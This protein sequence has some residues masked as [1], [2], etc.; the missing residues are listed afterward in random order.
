MLRYNSACRSGSVRLTATQEREMLSRRSAIRRRLTTVR[1]VQAIYMSGVPALVAAHRQSTPADNHP[2]DEPLFTPSQLSVEGLASCSPG[3]ADIEAR[4]RDA[5]LHE[6]LDEMRTL[7]H[8]KAG[9]V[10][11]KQRHVRHQRP[12]TR[13]RSIIEN[14][15]Q[16]IK[17]YSAKY[18]AARVAKLALTGPGDWEMTW[19]KLEDQD[20]RTM[21]ADD[22]PANAKNTETGEQNILLSEG[23]RLTSWI[24]MGA[25]RDTTNAAGMQDGESKSL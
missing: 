21:L 1:A 7:L 16:R 15:E 6:C 14:N 11:H 12:N 22:D 18:R 10:I 25:D 20:I 4:L 5:Q 2:E 3:I 8:L 17:T 9:L 24:W 19:R 23:R 13:A